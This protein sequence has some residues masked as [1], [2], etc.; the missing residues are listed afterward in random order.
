MIDENVDYGGTLTLTVKLPKWE[1]R[2]YPIL[3]IYY[4]DETEESSDR[5]TL[6][7]MEAWNRKT[8]GTYVT[9]SAIN[10]VLTTILARAQK[11][12]IKLNQSALDANALALE[13]AGKWLRVR[14]HIR[15]VHFYI[16]VSNPRSGPVKYD[17]ESGRI[18][19]QLCEQRR[20]YSSRYFSHETVKHKFIIP[21]FFHVWFRKFYTHIMFFCK[22]KEK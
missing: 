14:I 11:L 3:G 22:V 7:H 16:G 18:L 17:E 4:T 5:E 2:W 1:S 6:R 10:A 13:G 12:E 9:H 15:G 21:I 19:F 8:I 20:S